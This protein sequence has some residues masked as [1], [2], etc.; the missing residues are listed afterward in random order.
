[1]LNYLIVGGGTFGLS[2]A[3]SLR[4]R[5]YKVT[6]FG[7]EN[8]DRFDIPAEDAAS[9]DVNKV[10]RAD[11][12]DDI[13]YQDL[14]LKAIEKFKE[15]NKDAIKRFGRPLYVEC[16]AA[17]M[18]ATPEMNT[19]EQ[20]CLKN[21]TNAGMSGRLRML[22]GSPTSPPKEAWPGLQQARKKLPGGYLNTHAGY[23]DSGLTIRYLAEIAGEAGVQFVTGQRGTFKALLRNG[24]KVV[25]IETIDGEKH[26]GIVVVAAGSWTPS[27]IPEF[28]DLCVPVGQAVVQFKLDSVMAEKY[29]PSSFPVWFADVTKQGYYGF[30]V[31]HDGILKIANHGAGY[32]SLGSE[33][34]H[35]KNGN[36]MPTPAEIPVE[37]VLAYRDFF[38]AHFPDLNRLDIFKTRVCWYCDSWDGNFVVDRVPGYDGLFVAS[39]GSGHGFKFTPVLGDFIADIIEGKNTPFK[40]LFEW[41]FKPASGGVLDSIRADT[42]AEASK[43][44]HEQVLCMQEDLTAAAYAS[45]RLRTKVRSIVRPSSKL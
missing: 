24:G 20:Q 34:F 7:E 3:Y 11:Y 30:P 15:W 35:Q 5:G 9:N 8:Q 43:V 22:N 16:G 41:R 26:Y 23:A 39:G 32:P 25:G 42:G 18:T 37:A 14:G 45:G 29:S 19:F 44:L 12:G 1:M 36:T 4:E 13:L 6:V 40:K 33:G 21:L 17:F 10:V 27:L 31:T 28:Q 2:T 38:A